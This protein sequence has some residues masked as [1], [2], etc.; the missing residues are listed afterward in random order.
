[1]G[2][3]EFDISSTKDYDSIDYPESLSSK[4]S[5]KDCCN[6]SYSCTVYGMLYPKLFQVSEDRD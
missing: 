4:V 6:L 1:M 2:L 5:Y 3:K